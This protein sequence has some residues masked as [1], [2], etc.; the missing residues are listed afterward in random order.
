MSHQDPPSLPCLLPPGQT[1]PTRV[2]RIIAED[3]VEQRVLQ[4]QL[5]KSQEARQ[6]Q[7]A[8]PATA[9]IGGGAT[10][11]PRL[12]SHQGGDSSVASA[13]PSSG[14]GTTPLDRAAAAAAQAPCSIGE[15][16]SAVGPT[17]MAVGEEALVQDLDSNTL[18][19]FFDEL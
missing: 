4:L 19:R 14:L 8:T 2:V 1:K 13:G 15:G 12:S 7:P 11:L 18:L 16:G 5:H 17:Q 6:Q 9:L 10:G 3:S